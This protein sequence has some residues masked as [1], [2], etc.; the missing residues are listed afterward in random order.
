VRFAPD[1][2]DPNVRV[3]GIPAVEP[4]FGNLPAK[5]RGANVQRSI[6][7]VQEIVNDFA[8]LVP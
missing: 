5:L 7:K 8:N 2:P 4:S 1:G 6:R 3:Q